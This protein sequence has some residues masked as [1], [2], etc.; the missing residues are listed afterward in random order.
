MSCR[1]AIVAPTEAKNT[2][3]AFAEGNAQIWLAFVPASDMS[4]GT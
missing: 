4:G 3:L 2:F 1:I